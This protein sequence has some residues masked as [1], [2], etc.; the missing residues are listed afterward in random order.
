MYPLKAA[1]KIKA[2]QVSKIYMRYNGSR[3]T[4]VRRATSTEREEPKYWESRGIISRLSNVTGMWGH[5]RWDV[6]LPIKSRTC[7]ELGLLNFEAF[8]LINDHLN[9]RE[10][11][12]FRQGYVDAL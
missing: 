4:G 10:L 2:V 12:R 6:T 9:T 11:R 5:A 1:T 7:R 8:V 3:S